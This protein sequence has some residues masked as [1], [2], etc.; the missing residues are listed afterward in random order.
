MRTRKHSKE[1]RVAVL[2]EAALW[3]RNFVRKGRAVEFFDTYK[4][5]CAA[6]AL[7]LAADQIEARDD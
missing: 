2:R 3:L 7:E 4:D 5:V 1:N 6:E